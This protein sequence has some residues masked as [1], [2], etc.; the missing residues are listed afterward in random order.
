MSGTIQWL[1]QFDPRTLLVVFATIGVLIALPLEVLAL[2]R[3]RVLF[4]ARRAVRPARRRRG[5]A[6]RLAARLQAAH[7]GTDGGECDAAPARGAPI[8][9]DARCARHRSA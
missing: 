6:R 8:R 5:A 3:R 7:A 9:A 1:A 2:R 4:P